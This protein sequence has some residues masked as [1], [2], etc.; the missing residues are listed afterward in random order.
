MKDYILR[1][2]IADQ[3]PIASI[4]S[5][6]LQ[7]FPDLMACIL[8]FARCNFRCSYCYNV[9]LVDNQLKPLPFL[10]VAEFLSDRSNFLDGVVLSG[11]E[12]TLFRYLP[13]FV[14][15]IK[16]FGYQIKLDTNG[17]NPSMLYRLVEEGLLDYV[18]LDYKAPVHKYQAITNCTS[19]ASNVL[20]SLALLC[21]S[22]IPF[23]VRTTVHADL[24]N[25]GDVNHMIDDLESK[26]FTGKYYVQNYM[27]GITLGSLPLQRRTIRLGELKQPKSF[28]VHFRNF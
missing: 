2:D 19:L 6:T 9:D 13:E 25:E 24:L 4:T 5:C 7:D 15:Y 3:L 12:C 20:D 17:S 1:K 28:T 18:A 8:W 11:G 14:R 21:D 23:E 16:N 26:N 10:S 27:H 22:Q